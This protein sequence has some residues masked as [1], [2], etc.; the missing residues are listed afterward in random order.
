LN[1][2]AGYVRIF[3]EGDGFGYELSTYRPRPMAD[4][5]QR[6]SGYPSIGDA[7][8]AAELQLSSV[9]QIKRRRR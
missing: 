8:R 1:D 5:F 6:M 4:L 9:R 2:D 3:A 7:C